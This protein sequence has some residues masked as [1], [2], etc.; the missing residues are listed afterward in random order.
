MIASPPEKCPQVFADMVKKAQD[1]FIAHGKLPTVFYLGWENNKNLL[2]MELDMLIDAH[3]RALKSLNLPEP[4]S[5]GLI[6]STIKAIPSI[7][8]DQNADF[9]INIGTGW[10]SKEDGVRPSAAKDSKEIIVAKYESY[11][12]GSFLFTADI[13]EVSSARAITN[14]K[15]A[16]GRIFGKLSHLLPLRPI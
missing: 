3:M 14:K 4:D 12:K 10:S 15:W 16:Q 11:T 1:D 6:E 5:L 8:K 13:N 9:V 2:R 7:I